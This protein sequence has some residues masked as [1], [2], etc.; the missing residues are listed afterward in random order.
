[1][2]RLAAYLGKDIA[3]EKFFSAPRHSLVKQAWQP[4]E[5]QEATLNA[6]G[7][8]IGWYNAGGEAVSYKNTLPAWSDANLHGLGSSLIAPLWIA[9]VRSATPGQLVHLG[10]TQPVTYRNLHFLHNGFIDNFQDGF[11]AKLLPLI[12]PDILAAFQA[13]TDS[14]WLAALFHQHLGHCGN[15]ET[16]LRQTVTQLAAQAAARK[17][18][19]N[20]MVTDGHALYAIRH[21]INADCPSLYTLRN[22]ADFPDA[23]V[24]ASEAFDDDPG[25]RAVA[26]HQLISVD[27]EGRISTLPIA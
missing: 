6:D 11:R 7:F 1:M 10:N 9:N 16:A 15:I 12:D 27:R 3:L 21:A 17:V 25:W 23:V 18:L 22:G 24:I 14:A 13:D 8:G 20:L 5:M 4:R 2:C 19:M 26:E